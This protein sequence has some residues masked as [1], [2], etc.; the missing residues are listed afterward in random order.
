MAAVRLAPVPFEHVEAELAAFPI[1]SES[2]FCA[3]LVELDSAFVGDRQKCLW[4]AAE[5]E[6][7]F[8][9]PSVALDEFVMIRDRVWFGEHPNHENPRSRLPLADY[10]H[11]LSTQYLDAQGRPIDSALQSDGH[12]NPSPRA[13]LRWSWLCRALPPDLLRVARDVQN[14]DDSPFE[15][16]PI[17]ERLLQDHGFAETHLHLGA[18]ADFSLL[19]ANLMHALAVEEVKEKPFESP[20]AYFDDGRKLAKWLMWAATTRL[21]LAEWLFGSDGIGDRAKLLD[22]TNARWSGHMDAV[23]VS[24]LHRLISELAK[25]REGISPVRFSRGRTLYRSLIRPLPFLLDRWEERQ[26]FRSRYEPKCRLDVFENDPLARIVDWRRRLGSS[27][28]TIFVRESLRYIKKDHKDEDFARLFWQVIRVRCLLYRHLVLRPLTPGLQWFVR[29]FSRISPI[30][31]SLPDAVSMK[32][33]VHQSGSGKGLKSLEVRLGTEE[34]ASDCLDKVRQV[35]SV[36]TRP[37]DIEI[38]A[39]FHFSRD[40]GGGWKQGFPNAHGL[41]R[42]YP[43]IPRENWLKTQRDVG[44]PS[45]FRFA[46]FYL[47]QRRHAQALVSLLRA[48]PRALRTVRGVDLCTDEAGVPIWVMAPLIRWVREAG[49]NAHMKLQAQGVKRIPQLRTTVHAGEDFVNLLTGL[50]RIDDAIRHLKLEEGDRIGH[51]VALGLDPETW[52]KRTGQVIQTREERLFDLVW[53]WDCYAN[54]GVGGESGRLAYLQSNI[55]RLAREMFEVKASLT[56][57]DLIHF[58]RELHCEQQLKTLGFPDGSRYLAPTAARSEG[59]ETESRKLMQRYLRNTRVWWN[60][61]VLETIVFDKLEHELE[62]LHSLQRALRQK[63]GTLGLTVEVNPSSNLLISD[64]GL[65]EEHPIWRLSQPLDEVPPLS[66]CIGSDDPLTFAT[67]LPHEYQL[68]FDTMV[69]SGK[70]HE[71]ALGWL[72]KAREAGMRGRFTLPRS[73]TRYPKKL[74]PSLLEVRPLVPPP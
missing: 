25:G 65:L 14:A 10:L 45:G 18:A 68:L 71:V 30:R 44:N 4:R 51:G 1:A 41:D 70:S 13:R 5:R 50:R 12:K 66:V 38:G 64:L 43:G 42:S 39:V 26:R 56:P 63:V 33:A 31:Q 27:P 74:T 2:S 19:W 49:R 60:G 37:V 23:M 59:D 61:R 28:E 73:E 53:E 47:E 8:S 29:F 6:I 22:F 36:R 67:S 17:V 20:G 69:R 34:S 24:D 21:V 9:T 58:V 72:D 54:R 55:V 40:R 62:A 52:F 11:K 46:R 3:A 15:L 57:E 7:L 16:S 35:N 48:F 32:A